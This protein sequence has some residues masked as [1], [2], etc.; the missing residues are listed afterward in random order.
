MDPALERDL[1]ELRL[2][3]AD[4]LHIAKR[5]ALANWDNDRFYTGG[6]LYLLD[7]AKR[8]PRE[9]APELAVLLAFAK[10]ALALSRDY[11][12]SLTLDAGALRA[13]DAFLARAVNDLNRALVRLD[14][15]V[16]SYADLVTAI[17]E[18][19]PEGA[20][21]AGVVD[22]L[23][24]H[25]LNAAGHDPVKVEEARRDT[26]RLLAHVQFLLGT[27][28]K[29]DLVAEDR[30]HRSGGARSLREIREEFAA[31]LLEALSPMERLLRTLAG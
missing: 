4:L 27:M 18:A 25:S 11:A 22:L 12:R 24:A 6:V 2:A 1:H 17:D 20:P 23:R 14:G 7:L 10:G 29:W 31:P 26:V 3:V 21:L 13:H 28:L 30:F 16:A 19:L 15:P 9:H 8:A 5:R